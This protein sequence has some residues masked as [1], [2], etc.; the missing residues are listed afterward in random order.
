MLVPQQESGPVTRPAREVQKRRS[1]IQPEAEPRGARAGTLMSGRHLIPR[2]S[3]LADPTA[4][5]VGIRQG[6]VGVIQHVCK[7]RLRLQL[8][9]FLQFERFEETGVHGPVSGSAKDIQT[10]VSETSDLHIRRAVAV[11]VAGDT[12]RSFVEPVAERRV[13]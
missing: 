5:D 12:E 8:P 10:G 6:I 3:D 9:S 7:R 1:E 2:L 11:H 13:A 4:R